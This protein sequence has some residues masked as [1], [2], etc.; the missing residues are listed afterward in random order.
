MTY[1][2]RHY[3]IT[4]HYITLLFDSDDPGQIIPEPSPTAGQ[5]I[6]AAIIMAL[7]HF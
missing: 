6:V 3:L 2:G 5:K 7:A 1:K 4:A